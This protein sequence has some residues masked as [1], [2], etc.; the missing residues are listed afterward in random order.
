MHD[1]AYV[2]L[3]SASGGACGVRVARWKD[4]ARGGGCL[5]VAGGGSGTCPRDGAARVF[6]YLKFQKSQVGTFQTWDY[7]GSP[8]QT[9]F[10]L[11]K[12]LGLRSLRSSSRTRQRSQILP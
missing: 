12:R 8:R 6:L 1:Q 2:S 5:G 9:I 3:L 11:R 10:S 4:R 7:L